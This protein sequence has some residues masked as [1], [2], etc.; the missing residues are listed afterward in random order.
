MMNSWFSW[1]DKWQSKTLIHVVEEG[2]VEAHTVAERC[3]DGE[4]ETREDVFS[5][6]N[7]VTGRF[8][9]ARNLAQVSVKILVTDHFDIAGLRDFQKTRPLLQRCNFLDP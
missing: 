8:M 4:T 3:R 5:P 2:T 9:G 6:G 1:K 7:T